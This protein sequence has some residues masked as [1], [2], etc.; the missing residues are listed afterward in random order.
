MNRKQ[1]T[2][3][4][5]IFENPVRSNVRWADVMSLFDALG[6]AVSEGRGSR[7]C[8]SLNGADAVFHAPH[9]PETDKG[10]LKAVRDFIREAG[11]EP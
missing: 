2:T 3:L 7:V 8:V 4:A 10:A 9:G 6:C 11:V 1:R 5:A